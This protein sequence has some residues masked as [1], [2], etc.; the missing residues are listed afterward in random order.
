M[1]S[2]RKDIYSDDLL[3]V[4]NIF[5][6]KL[7]EIETKL[8]DDFVTNQGLF[9]MTT[10]Y[11]E[12]SIR[13]LMRIVLL[14]IPEKLPKESYTITRQQICM[15]ADKGHSAIIDNEL[16]VLF[17]DG[18]KNQ[19]EKLL[20]ILFNKECKNNSIREEVENTIKK[21]A[22]ISLYRNALIHNGGKISSEINEKVKFFKP[23]TK[24]KSDI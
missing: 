17:K 2:E 10:A 22:E 1:V 8:G 9:I 6:E 14:K 21:L 18:V 11:F 19:L 23:K 12:D 7:G 16:F 3:I 5:I 13:E 20:K 24:K 4:A 15:I